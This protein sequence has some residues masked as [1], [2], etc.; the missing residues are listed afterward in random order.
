MFRKIETRAAHAAHGRSRR[1]VRLEDREH[2]AYPRDPQRRQPARRAS[3][4]SSARASTMSRRAARDR[5]V[6]VE[7]ADHERAR[8]RRDHR[9]GHDQRRAWAARCAGAQTRRGRS[10]ATAGVDAVSGPLLDAKGAAELLNV[11]ASWVL[12]EARADRS[13]TCGWAAM[14]GSTPTSCSS[15]AARGIEGRG[16]GSRTG[17]LGRLRWRYISKAPPHRWNGR[18]HGQHELGP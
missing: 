11:P 8:A 1:S 5:T 6:V 16:D 4:A 9:R 15:G 3:R 12:A 17:S 13:R 10:L 2:R 7:Q 14:C 18:G